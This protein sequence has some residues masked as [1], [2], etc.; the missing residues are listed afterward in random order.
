M[1][2]DC[3]DNTVANNVF[4]NNWGVAI[5]CDTVTTP[6]NHPIRIVGNFILSTNMFPNYVGGGGLFMEVAS[7]AWI[8]N[9]VIVTSGNPAITLAGSHWTRVLFNTCFANVTPASAPTCLSLFAEI[10]RD[11]DG[12]TRHTYDA[13]HNLVAYNIFARYGDQALVAVLQ[14]SSAN[15]TSFGAISYS[16]TYIGNIFF[17]VGPQFRSQ[18]NVSLPPYIQGP[19]GYLDDATGW[20][21]ALCGGNPGCSNSA[22]IVTNPLFVAANATNFSTAAAFMLA[23]NSPASGYAL[24]NYNV[25]FDFSGNPRQPGS[26]AAGAFDNVTKP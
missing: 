16:N 25:P 12:V 17:N 22:N 9:N 2:G 21:S 1:T 14:D 7:S 23:S 6:P 10:G 19:V 24:T 3:A 13:A 11:T 26:T 15:A 20:A 5:H 8:I 18:M 4:S